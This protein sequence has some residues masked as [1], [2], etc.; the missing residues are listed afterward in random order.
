MMVPGISDGEMDVAAAGEDPSAARLMANA[1]FAADNGEDDAEGLG[2]EIAYSVQGMADILE[3]GTDLEREFVLRE[4]HRL[5]D[6]C[7]EPVVEYV[8]PVIFDFADSWNVNLQFE[9]GFVMANLSKKKLDVNPAWMV[10]CLALKELQVVETRVNP[11]DVADFCDLWTDSLCAALSQFHAWEENAQLNNSFTA[12]TQLTPELQT[13]LEWLSALAES[14]ILDY[15]RCSAKLLGGIAAEAPAGFRQR[16]LLGVL[17]KLL[18][19]PQ[20]RVVC[21][22]L[23]AIPVVTRHMSPTTFEDFIWSPLNV[24]LNSSDLLVAGSALKALSDMCSMHREAAMSQEEWRANL[25]VNSPSSFSASVGHGSHKGSGRLRLSGGLSPSVVTP[26]QSLDL[27]NVSNGSAMSTSGAKM[28]QPNERLTKIYVP[29]AFQKHY[30][31]ARSKTLT[32]LREADD[33]TY[34]LLQI[35]AE[36]FGELMYC[37]TDV[38]STSYRRHAFKAY[39][40]LSTCNGADVRRYCAYNFPGMCICFGV[41]YSSELSQLAELFAKDK[42]VAVRTTFAAGFHES[43]QVLGALGKAEKLQPTL[44]LLLDDVDENVQK[45]IIVHLAE[46]LPVIWSLVSSAQAAKH[47]AA[48]AEGLASCAETSQW[49]TQILLIS[50]LELASRSAPQALIQESI[51]PLLRQKMKSSSIHEVRLTAAAALV[52]VIHFVAD[53]QQRRLLIE[54]YWTLEPGAKY[55]HRMLYVHAGSVALDVYSCKSYK[56]LFGTRM[57]V[58]VSDSHSSVRLL[59]ARSMEKM[60]FWFHTDPM[61]QSTLRELQADADPDVRDK[62]RRI[63]LLTVSQAQSSTISSKMHALETKKLMEEDRLWGGSSLGGVG[64]SGTIGSGSVSGADGAAISRVSRFKAWVTRKGKATGGKEKNQLEKSVE[65]PPRDSSPRIVKP[66]SRRGSRGGSAPTTPRSSLEGAIRTN[67]MQG[68]FDRSDTQNSSRSNKSGDMDDDDLDDDSVP[69]VEIRPPQYFARP[70]SPSPPS[71]ATSTSNSV[72]NSSKSSS[73]T[74][75]ATAKNESSSAPVV[76]VAS[77]GE[78]QEA[79]E[80]KDANN[81]SSSTPKSSS[82]SVQRQEEKKKE[83]T[84]TAAVAAPVVVVDRSSVPNERRKSFRE[85]HFEETKKVLPAKLPANEARPKQRSYVPGMVYFPGEDSG[86]ESSLG[87]SPQDSPRAAS[88]TG[89][90]RA[91][92]GGV[93]VCSPRQ[94]QPVKVPVIRPPQRPLN[95]SHVA[96]SPSGSA[97]SST[98]SAA[99]NPSEV[100]SPR[101]R[102]GSPAVVPVTPTAATQ[103]QNKQSAARVMSSQQNVRTVTGS[104]GSSVGTQPPPR[105]QVPQTGRLPME[106]QRESSRDALSP[107]M[108]QQ[109]RISESRS[110]SALSDSMPMAGTASSSSAKGSLSSGTKVSNPVVRQPQSVGGHK[111][112]SSAS[113]STGTPSEYAKRNQPAGTPP[114]PAAA[115]PAKQMLSKSSGNIKSSARATDAARSKSSERAGQA[116]SSNKTVPGGAANAA[117]REKG[118]ERSVQRMPA[119]V[120]AGTGTTLAGS[121]KSSQASAIAAS[122]QQSTERSSDSNSRVNAVIAGT[123]VKSS[124]ASSSGSKISSTSAGTASARQQPQV[125]QQQ[126]AKQPPSSAKIASINAKSVTPT[127]ALPVKPAGAPPPPSRPGGLSSSVRQTQASTVPAKPAGVAA[128]RNPAQ[129]PGTS[130]ARQ[131][132]TTNP[133]AKNPTPSAPAAAKQSTIAQPKAPAK[134]GSPAPPVITQTGVK[135]PVAREPSAP[136]QPTKRQQTA[137]QPAVKQPTRPTAGPGISS[138]PKQSPNPTQT[139]NQNQDAAKPKVHVGVVSFPGDYVLHI[140]ILSRTYSLRPSGLYAAAAPRVYPL[141]FFLILHNTLYIQRLTLRVRRRMCTAIETPQIGATQL[142]EV[143]RFAFGDVTLLLIFILAA[144]RARA[145][146]LRN[147]EK[148]K[149]K[150]EAAST[151]G[152]CLVHARSRLTKSSYAL[153]FLSM[154]SVKA[155]MLRHAIIKPEHEKEIHA[156]CAMLCAWC[157]DVELT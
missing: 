60:A 65:T 61:F 121:P 102:T 88:L 125:S 85:Q 43:V 77:G 64:S 15:R 113:L 99:A 154:L 4:V 150:C 124:S 42:D 103:I 51:I 17:T 151:A 68:L 2:E 63:H 139:Q 20:P 143:E 123:A 86:S 108:A 119:H 7:H 98:S 54:K 35:V 135:Q 21:A 69:V 48:L 149:N 30:I 25:S 10:I 157:M 94:K 131:P 145:F 101:A 58:C 107:R 104:T 112:S 34:A 74:I 79:A 8:L 38:A 13:L 33:S 110:A 89:S 55:T 130:P 142:Q 126:A 14:E 47:N 53:A 116:P 73:S 153:L 18:S 76:K 52:K 12:T 57:L 22:A 29:G 59:L 91:A 62:A 46:V 129:Q 128:V 95:S 109:R 75:N 90:P 96:K 127:R 39:A 70:S 146:G 31:W 152:Q 118:T 81:A 80:K 140:T 83:P 114:P 71:A 3:F 40:D 36:V 66:K 41:K 45:E 27:S 97:L 136:L 37:V 87:G 105:Q 5:I 132:N 106:Q 23:E 156:F 133:A 148:A 138:K 92:A 49:R 117:S 44:M 155:G 120:A 93:A 147:S 19:D 28:Y 78:P 50:Q 24:A 134:V 11:D 144:A 100:K 82:A 67:S 16:T 6:Y 72:I 111:H 137:G 115:A 26:S 32:D 141:H 56:A 122:R 84:A 9:A 1:G